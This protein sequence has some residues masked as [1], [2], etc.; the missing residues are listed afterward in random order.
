MPAASRLT[1]KICEG[2]SVYN[3]VNLYGCEN[4][5]GTKIGSFVEVQRGARVGRNCKV[6]SY[7]F[8]CEGVTIE[9]EV[10]IGHGVNFINDKY[11]WAMTGNGRLQTAEEWTVAPTLVRSGASI[12][13]GATVLGGIRVGERAVIGAGAVVTRD[14]PAGAVVAGNPGQVIRENRPERE[15]S[16]PSDLTF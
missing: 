14:V 1:C 6:S 7:T 10:F 9:D 13:T 11:L 4:G 8:I 5:D 16:R 15:D 2:A 12:G 3:F